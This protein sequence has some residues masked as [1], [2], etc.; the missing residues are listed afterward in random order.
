[1]RYKEDSIP[2][3]IIA[4]KEYALAHLRDWASKG[5]NYKVYKLC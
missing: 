1:M 5:L 3:M 4:G 2:L